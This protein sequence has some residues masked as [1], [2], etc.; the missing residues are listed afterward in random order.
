MRKS[1]K[2]SGFLLS[3]LLSLMF[4]LE[5]TVPAWIFLGLHFWKGI[6][7]W[8]F[9]ISIILWGMFII[10]RVVVFGSLTRAGNFKD[11]PKE[12]KNPY[13]QKEYKKK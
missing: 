5:W 6:S 13:S 3:L 11:P 1:E 7:V 2:K 4:N 10:F 9:V 8:W 12:N